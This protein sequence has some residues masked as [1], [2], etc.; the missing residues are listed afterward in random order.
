MGGEGHGAGTPPPPLREELLPLLAQHGRCRCRG[1][2]E[3]WLL[4]W[5]V[6]P[7]GDTP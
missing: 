4:L 5:I 3:A 7:M 6:R 2:A 1:W